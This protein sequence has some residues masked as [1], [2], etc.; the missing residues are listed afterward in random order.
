MKDNLNSSG[1][2]RME[3][4]RLKEDILKLK[5]KINFYKY[6]QLTGLK[7]RNDFVWDFNDLILKDKPFMV[8]L[9][10]INNLKSINTK[11]GYVNGGDTLIK[12]MAKKLKTIFDHSFIYRIGGD[13]FV[14]FDFNLNEY[15]DDNN[16]LSVVSK[17]IEPISHMDIGTESEIDINNILMEMDKDMLKLKINLDRRGTRQII[18]VHHG[19]DMCLNIDGY[20]DVNLKYKA[21]KLKL[22]HNG[23]ESVIYLKE[24]D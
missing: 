10:D 12:K 19:L 4:L 21:G 20:I 8:H 1:E 18:K 5:K 7:T 23:D 13:E 15:N 11:Y 17:V 22:E 9:C 2:S 16:E 24:K 14:V 6:D 3:I